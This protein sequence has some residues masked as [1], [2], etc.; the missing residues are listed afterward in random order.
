MRTIVV[1]GG[2]RGIGRAVALSF[3][4]PGAHLV[5]TAR[6]ARQLNEV[7][8]EI[9]ARGGEATVIPMDVS[10][11]ASVAH[12][13]GTLHG[14]VRQVDVLVNNAGVGGGEPVQGS[15]VAR[16]KRTL[17]TNLF[18]TYLVTRQLLPLMG[19]GGRV[20]NLSSV[21]G[22]FGVAGYSAYCASK[23]GVIGFTRAL[24]LEV[25]SRGI[26]ANAICPGWVDTEMAAS[27]MHAGAA[28]TRQTFEQFR[29]DAIGAVPIQRIIQ[30]E[31]V[32]GLIH[33]LA[34]PEASAI[35]GQTFNICGGQTMD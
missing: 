9:R 10:D 27:G 1:T 22:R 3:A 20:I 8:D 21:L 26:T 24:A 4:A 7:A 35:T 11:E 19:P 32:A 34:S 28:A 17:D 23:H 30:P 31:E 29:D 18:G 25:A 15:D 33:F 2:G 5:I 16:W 13:F 12:G 6:T 14:Q